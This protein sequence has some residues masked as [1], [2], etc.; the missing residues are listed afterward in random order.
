M[1]MDVSLRGISIRHRL[2]RKYG[3]P[4]AVIL[5]LVIAAVAAWCL[6]V[7]PPPIVTAKHGAYTDVRLYHDEAAQVAK[8]RDF[9]QAT[10]ELQRLHHYPLKPFVTVRQPTE[11]VFAARFGWKA[12]QY[13][14]MAALFIS[15]FLWVIA[16]E[17]KLHLVERIALLGAM[18]AG[19]S[20][21]TQE[22]I[23][24]LQE[25]P[26][27]E[28]IGIALA[29]WIGWRRQWWLPMIPVLLGL[30][31]RELVLPFALLALAF[32]AV[33][34]Q[35][36]EV[37]GW[38]ALLA[39]WG[40]FMAWHAAHVHAILLPTDIPSKGWHGLQGF[41]GFLKSVIF[42]STIQP[43]RLGVAL[44]VAALPLVGWASLRGQVG[45]FCNLLVWGYVL[46]IGLFSRA[47]TF[48]WGAI[49]LPWYFVGYIL[50]PRA[51]LRIWAAWQARGP[52]F[53]AEAETPAQNAA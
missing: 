44:L 20:Q 36:R 24:A 8:G 50:L 40:A 42:T 23:L 14:C 51:L 19:G 49:M 6:T 13:F 21:V 32:A 37:S 4:L 1:H 15:T 12:V 11:V 43:L 35:W 30:F 45:L 41:S 10:A 17:G 52:D 34:R 9:Y 31:I 46:M 27:G 3:R 39:V 28:C 16:T 47:D 22:G 29:L 26:A 7:T 18:G 25:Y 5:V 2:P 33:Q 48:Y 53:A 38:V